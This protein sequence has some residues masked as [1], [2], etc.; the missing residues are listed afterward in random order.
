MI[1]D[2]TQDGF[3]DLIGAVFLAI[4]ILDL[5]LQNP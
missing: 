1:P 2:L 5:R 3:D 4:L